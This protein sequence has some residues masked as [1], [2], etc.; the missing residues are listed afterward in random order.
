MMEKDEFRGASLN[1]C[2]LAEVHGE[3]RS[4]DG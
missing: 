2:R 4:H 1:A 3:K